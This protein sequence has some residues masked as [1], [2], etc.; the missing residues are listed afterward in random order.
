MGAI[1]ETTEQVSIED[2]I[3]DEVE[4]DDFV[5]LAKNT[6]NVCKIVT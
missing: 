4:L 2:L 6:V 5:D 1:N 3:F